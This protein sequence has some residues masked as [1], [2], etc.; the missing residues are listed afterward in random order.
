MIPRDLE[1]AKFIL[2]LCYVGAEGH[3]ELL[4]YPVWCFFGVKF[5]EFRYIVCLRLGFSCILDRTG[6][7]PFKS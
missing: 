7:T 1:Y 5:S 2:L 6:V 3:L 4:G